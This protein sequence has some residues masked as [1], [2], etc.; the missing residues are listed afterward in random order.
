MC[1]IICTSTDADN[2]PSLSAAS[3]GIGTG[4]GFHSEVIVTE[5][6]EEEMY[7]RDAG[8]RGGEYVPPASMLPAHIHTGKGVPQLS[9]MVALIEAQ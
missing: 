7:M 3:T 9:S 8:Q 6:E 1:F 5:E 2:Q 4:E